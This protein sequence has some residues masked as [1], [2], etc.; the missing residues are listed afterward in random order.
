MGDGDDVGVVEHEFHSENGEEETEGVFED[1][2]SGSDSRRGVALLL[3]CV[4]GVS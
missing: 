1:M 2:A 3:E 4:S